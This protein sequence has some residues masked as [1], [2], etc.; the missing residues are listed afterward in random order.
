MRSMYSNRQ[1]SKVAYYARHHGI[2]AASRHFKISHSNVLRWYNH[3]VR[4]K[5][6]IYAVGQGRK[7]SYPESIEE[8]LVK[9]ILEKRDELTVAVSKR[10]LRLKALSLIKPHL[11]DFKASDGWMKKFMRRNNLVLRAGTSLAQSLPGDLEEK[12][13]A[14]HQSIYHVRMLQVDL[15]RR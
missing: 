10:T 14:F 15:Q 7:I 2:R 5:G 13:R 8:D 6:I 11:S 9:W 1:K 3:R 4:C 12:V